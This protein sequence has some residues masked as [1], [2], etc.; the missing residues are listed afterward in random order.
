MKSKRMYKNFILYLFY[1]FLSP[2]F[3]KF[4]KID[5]K[6][7]ISFCEFKFLRIIF[8]N[9]I[10]M[11]FINIDMHPWGNVGDLSFN[12]RKVKITLSKNLKKN[13]KLNLINSNHNSFVPIS[14][15]IYIN[16]KNFT[17][18]VQSGAAR[19]S[20][21]YNNK[22]YYYFCLLQD[23][24]VG[25]YANW[26]IASGQNK[27]SR[28]IL[29]EKNI[30][31]ILKLVKSNPLTISEPII[32]VGIETNYSHWLISKLPRV[33][34]L[35]KWSKKKFPNVKI[36]LSK[37]VKNF[38]RE[39]LELLKIPIHFSNE[40]IIRS[41]SFFLYNTGIND[42][43]Q[44]RDF[45]TLL[46]TYSFIKNKNN[47]KYKKIFISRKNSNRFSSIE[48]KITPI[49]IKRGFKIIC[50]ENFSFQEQIKLFSQCNYLISWHGAGLANLIWMPSSTSVLEINSD[51]FK[52]N[53][54]QLVAKNMSINFKNI[55]EKDIFDYLNK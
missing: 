23:S 27:W 44:K 50:C 48:K 47:R 9:R 51:F 19:N 12:K 20:I 10:E 7:L 43:A 31:N 45:E 35:Y 28:G 42:L 55:N 8:L 24:F 39:S 17:I 5:L 4:L 6:A 2:I 36:L 54:F 46:S 22:I 34:R 26:D 1:H 18:H 11:P 14:D 40:K 16:F 30:F 33:L 53:V 3:N 25:H 52:N 13:S 21:I 38:Q 29:E 49:L 37:E 15:D 41:K 32:P